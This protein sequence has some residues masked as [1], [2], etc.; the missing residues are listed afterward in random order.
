MTGGGTEQEENMRW[1]TYHVALG[2]NLGDREYY[3]TSAL[4]ALDALPYTRLDRLSS[5]YETVP[6]GPVDQGMFLNAAAELRSAFDPGML[7]GCMLGIEAALGRKRGVRW[8]ARVIDLDLLLCGDR[9]IDAS[10]ML[11]IPH[12][13]LRTRPF[14]L[15]PLAEIAPDAVCPPDGRTVREL[16]VDVQRKEDVRWYKK[17][18]PGD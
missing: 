14:V 8:G 10:P 18:S 9:E 2:A 7:L 4:R 1:Y 16:C 15:V 6:V 3:L 12:P 17:L 13:M 5:L 11:V